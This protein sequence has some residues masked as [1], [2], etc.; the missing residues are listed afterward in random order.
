[1]DACKRWLSKIELG[2]E[3]EAA[4]S[5]LEATIEIKPDKI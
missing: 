1:M 3:I 4:K 2:F 5:E